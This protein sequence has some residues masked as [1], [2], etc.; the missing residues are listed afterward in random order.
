MYVHVYAYIY[1]LLLQYFQDNE[2]N[3]YYLSYL[4]HT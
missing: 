1:L 4:T 2:E 3:I